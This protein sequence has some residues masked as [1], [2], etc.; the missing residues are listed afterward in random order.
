MAAASPEYISGSQLV[1]CLSG[2][3]VLD[4]CFLTDTQYAVFADYSGAGCDLLCYIRS[5]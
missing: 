5:S 3:A 1:S 2:F 4:H